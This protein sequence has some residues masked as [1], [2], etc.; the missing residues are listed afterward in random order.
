MVPYKGL[1]SHCI[2]SYNEPSDDVVISN[3]KIVAQ[4][5]WQCQQ[6]ADR[7]QHHL[8]E[9]GNVMLRKLGTV[10]FAHS[11]KHVT[12]KKKLARIIFQVS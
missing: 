3:G 9:W 11:E 4:L 6:E 8:H 2:S 12:V 5:I 1:Q 7:K 10:G